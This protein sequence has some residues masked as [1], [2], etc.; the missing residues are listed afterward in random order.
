[1]AI[2]REPIGNHW[3]D[4][5]VNLWVVPRVIHFMRDAELAADMLQQAILSS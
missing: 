5:K 1:M 3:E 2:Q 4:I